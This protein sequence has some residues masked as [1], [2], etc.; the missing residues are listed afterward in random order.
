MSGNGSAGLVGTPGCCDERSFN[1]SS[2][3]GNAGNISIQILDGPTGFF[4][5]DGTNNFIQLIASSSSGNAGN[6]AIDVGGSIHTNWS[7]Y[8]T[9]T[10][11]GNVSINTNPSFFTSGDVYL[12][13][14]ILTNAST[15]RAGSVSIN[16]ISI[17]NVAYIQATGGIFGGDVQLNASN[18]SI[19][20]NG[21]GNPKFISI[22]TSAAIAAGAV[23]VSAT[24][25]ITFA[26]AIDASSPVSG[27]NVSL[28]ITD[29]GNVTF[30]ATGVSSPWR[31]IDTSGSTGGGGDIN[32]F[33]NRSFLNSSGNGDAG[34]VG[35]PG[36]CDERS[37]NASSTSGDAGNIAVTILNGPSGRFGT[38]S[39]ANFMQ[40]IANSATGKGGNI[41]VS[42]KGDIQATW[43]FLANGAEAGNISL[44]SDGYINTEGGAL[45]ADGSNGNA[46][47]VVVSAQSN[48]STGYLSAN[49]TNGLGGNLIAS[50]AN[51]SVNI[52]NHTGLV[53][54][55]AS[56]TFG[57]GQA[58][59]LAKTA[60]SIA[61]TI[62]VSSSAKLGGAAVVN[63]SGTNAP[64]YVGDNGVYNI[65]ARGAISGGSIAV[66]ASGAVTFQDG[67]LGRPLL[68]SAT[69]L[70]GTGGSIFISQSSTSNLNVNL[71]VN[72]GANG[73]QGYAVVTAN[74]TINNS[75]SASP[76]SNIGMFPNTALQGNIFAP[77]NVFLDHDYTLTVGPGNRPTIVDDTTA[78]T[79]LLPAGSL[80]AFSSFAIRNLTIVTASSTLLAPLSVSGSAEFNSITGHGTSPVAVITAG[81]LDVMNGINNAS[82]LGKAPDVILLSNTNISVDG[83]VSTVG[84]DLNTTHSGNIT[85]VGRH[86]DWTGTLDS[87]GAGAS[88]FG[89]QVLVVGHGASS[90]TG[91]DILANGNG[92][93]GA[94]RVTLLAPS[95]SIT[96]HSITASGGNGAG[97]IIQL[98]A[99]QITLTGANSR[100][101]SLDATSF[102]SYAGDI[103]L[104]G[105]TITV[106]NGDIDASGKTSGGR[107]NLHV[108]NGSLQTRDILS[109]GSSFV[110]G[111]ANSGGSVYI[112]GSGIGASIDVEDITVEGL[113]GAFAGGITIFNAY[114]QIT[115]QS[116][117]ARS[118]SNHAG[119]V[120]LVGQ[121]ISITGYVPGGNNTTAGIDL[122]AGNGRGGGL[123]ALVST[124]GFFVAGDVE[125]YGT[126]TGLSAGNLVVVAQSGIV[127][128]GN[129]NVTGYNGARGGTVSMSNA[130]GAILLGNPGSDDLGVQGV[131]TQGT[132]DGG[133][134]IITAGTYLAARPGASLDF[135]TASSDGDGG[136]LTLVSGE[137]DHSLS[138]P[139]SMAMGSINTGGV[140]GGDVLIANLDSGNRFGGV[141]G[142]VE[143]GSINTE[144][145]GQ[146][147]HSGSV[148]ISAT[149]TVLVQG[150]ISTRNTS[151]APGPKAHGGGV[152]IS[153]T[154]TIEIT[155]GLPDVD[156]TIAG[157]IVL[158]GG[159]DIIL[160]GA[161]QPIE[162]HPAANV[163]IFSHVAVPLDTIVSGNTQ[164][165]ITPSF[166]SSNLP[167]GGFIDLQLVGSSLTVN[168]GSDSYLLAPIT[169]TSGGITV[170]SVTG[171][172]GGNSG[173]A[174]ALVSRAAIDVT[175]NVTTASAAN[176]DGG[177]LILYSQIGDVNV[178]GFVSTAG[179]SLNPDTDGGNVSLLAAQAQ[180]FVSGAASN[181][182]INTV[183]GNHA[184]NVQIVGGSGI[185][186]NNEIFAGLTASGGDVILVNPLGS[187][188][189]QN[190]NS[191]TSIEV[192]STDDKGGFVAL[193]L[194]QGRGAGISL[195]GGVSAFSTSSQ[196]TT[197]GTFIARLQQGSINSPSGLTINVSCGGCPSGSRGGDVFISA[198]GAG[199]LNLN[200]N[201]NA[202]GPS[203]GSITV[204]SGGALQLD[205]NNGFGFNAN[206]TDTIDGVA[207]S[208]T[209]ISNTAQAF[210]VVGSGTPTSGSTNYVRGP[211]RVE[212][213]HGGTLT[214]V[215]RGGP[216]SIP[217]FG[218]AID[219]DVLNAAE[220]NGAH[221]TL[222]GTELRV[223]GALGTGNVIDVSGL[224]DGAGG[225]ITIV[226]THPIEPLV[227][228]TTAGTNFINA[229]LRARSGDGLTV[230]AGDGGNIFINAAGGV[231][232]DA[233][234]LDVAGARNGGSITIITNTAST[235]TVDDS[236]T[237]NGV[238]GVLT[239][240]GG[241][242]LDTG[243]GGAITLQNFGGGISIGD[244]HLDVSVQAANGNGGRITL[245]GSN[246]MVFGDLEANGSQ[247]AGGTG[248]G[249]E[250]HVTAFFSP[251]I[252]NGSQS[253]NSFIEGSLNANA[254]ADSG[255]GGLVELTADR[256]LTVDAAQISVLATG[257]GKGGQII[258]SGDSVTIESGDL[259][260]RGSGEGDGGLVRITSNNDVTNSA[261]I[262]TA[263]GSDG[264]PQGG[265]I[266]INL[267]SG[268]F[269]NTDT[270]ILESNGTNNNSAT[271]GSV[272]ITALNNNPLA[273]TNAGTI[274]ATGAAGAGQILFDTTGSS[275]T[276]NDSS[277]LVGTL[278]TTGTISWTSID[279]SISIF[280]DTIGGTVTGQGPDI[281]VI[282][283]SGDLT[284][285]ALDATNGNLILQANDGDLTVGG[286]GATAT[287]GDITLLSG[288]DHQIN[289][290][291]AQ[292]NTVNI[293]T[294]TLN[295]TGAGTVTALSGDILINQ[296]APGNFNMN[297]GVVTANSGNGNVRINTT[298]TITGTVDVNVQSISGL[299]SANGADITITT[300]SDD[301]HTN[302]VTAADGQLTLAA[303]G[304]NLIVD[305]N[306][307]A[308]GG[309]VTLSS[310]NGAS[311]SITVNDVSGESVLINTATLNAVGA[312]PTVEAT[313][314]DI[315]FNQATPGSFA[316]TGGDLVVSSG[317][318]VVFNGGNGI[319]NA[320]VNSISDNGP[321]SPT[322]NATGSDITVTVA[323]GNLTAS[324]VTASS[325]QLT[326]QATAGDLF[327]G[328]NATA[329]G[330]DLTLISGAG[331]DDSITVQNGSGD[332][333]F[334]QTRTLNTTGTTPT[335]TANT[336]DI[337]FNQ[338]TPG[339]FTMAGGNLVVSLG[340][341][342]NF[343][344][345]A[346]VIDAQVTSISDNGA[347]SPTVTATG[348]DIT[349]TT[350][351][352]NLT[353]N[354]VE[355]TSG[356]LTLAAL[357]GN[358][359]VAGDATAT[360]G[361]LNL[362]SANGAANSITIH[363]GSGDSVFIQTRTLIPTGITPT[364]T[365]NDG[366]INFNQAVPGS[367]T[368]NGGNLVVGNG[369]NV[370]F[371]GGN[372]IINATVNSI[373]DNG[374]TSPTVSATGSAITV[375]TATG[376]LT[377]NS[378]SSSSGLLTLAA[379]AGNLL[380][381]GDATATGGNLT[382]RSGSGAAN[383]IT[384]HNG[385]GNSV[386]IQTQTLNP[387]GLSPTIRANTGDINFNQATPGQF[388]M[389][390][391][392]LV[393]GSGRN[394][395]F[396]GG[397]GIIDV[398][399]TS[400]SDNGTSSPTVNATGDSIDISV[401]TGNLTANTVSANNGSLTLEATS[402]NLFVG[403][404]ASAIDGDLTLNSATGATDSVT[405]HNAS[406]DSVFI[407]TRTLNA[408]GS[409]PTI[410]ANVGDIN[411]ND[412]AAGSFS[413][414][415]G[416]LVAVGQNVVFNGGAGT[417]NAAANSINA[418]V[419]GGAETMTVSVASGDLT[420]GGTA[421][422]MTT[423][424]PT[425]IDLT[426]TGGNLRLTG[427]VQADGG[428]L[429]LRSGPSSSLIIA[430][431]GEGSGTEVTANSSTVSNNG[432]LTATDGDLTLLSLNGALLSVSGAG[433]LE[434]TGVG[435]I[436]FN[437]TTPGTAAAIQMTGGTIDANGGANNVNFNGGNGAVT[438]Q[439]IA[440]ILGTVLAN[441]SSVLIQT[442]GGELTAGD[443]DATNGGL[444]LTANGTGLNVIDTANLGATQ[445][446]SL[447]ST[448]ANGITVGSAGGTGVNIDAGTTIFLTANTGGAVAADIVLNEQAH[449]TTTTGNIELTSGRD[450]SVGI[451]A[452]LS[453]GADVLATT[454]GAF[455]MTTGSSAIAVADV[456]VN[457]TTGININGSGAS[458]ATL[459][460]GVPN[461]P[462]ARDSN[463]VLNPNDQGSQYQV[464]N[465]G[466]IQL[467]SSGTAATDDIVLNNA[468]LTSYGANIN[469]VGGHDITSLSGGADLAAVGGNIVLSAGRDLN[470][471][472]G[473]TV[474]AVATYRV[475]S[476]MIPID[477]NQ[478]GDYQGG[479]IF[480]FA[481]TQ[482]PGFDPPDLS[483]QA[484]YLLQLTRLAESEPLTSGLGIFHAPGASVSATAPN[485]GAIQFIAKE[486]GSINVAGSNILHADGGMI[487]IDPPGNITLNGIN[488][489][490][491]APGIFAGGGG[492]S[493]P[494][495]TCCGGGGGDFPLLVLLPVD[496][497]ID[498][499]RTLSLG[500]RVPTDVVKPLEQYMTTSAGE[501]QECSPPANLNTM[502]K[503]APGA[504]VKWA[505]STNLCQPIYFERDDGLVVFGTPGTTFVPE[506][507]KTVL[508]REGTVLAIAG[509]SGLVVKSAS[510]ATA[511]IPPGS[512]V[513]VEQVSSGTVKFNSLQGC[514]VKITLGDG[515]GTK[516]FSAAPGE[517][518]IIGDGALPTPA[519]GTNEQTPPA[520]S[521]TPNVTKAMPTGQTMLQKLGTCNLS[522]FP[523]KLR[524][525]IEKFLREAEEA[526]LGNGN[527]TP[528]S[529]KPTEN[530]PVAFA[531]EAAPRT[532]QI[533]LTPV[534]Y[535]LTAGSAKPPVTGLQTMNTGNATIKAT[536]LG[537]RVVVNKNGTIVLNDGEI[538]VSSHQ[539]T[540]VNIGDHL[541]DIEPNTLVLLSRD[542]DLVKV[543][544]LWAKKLNAVRAQMKDKFVSIVEGQEVAIG[545]S[546]EA[547]LQQMKGD[548]VA[549]R[550]VRG[551]DLPGGHH[552]AC[553]EFAFVSLIQNSELLSKLTKSQD[554]DD[555]V[556]ADRVFKMA[557]CI[558][559]VTRN[560]G[561]Y[562][563][564][565]L[566]Q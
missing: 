478:V 480:L 271:G 543:G 561:A 527:K 21:S 87:S 397:A 422:I 27:G 219:L 558:S 154:D 517:E 354:S 64:I 537:A 29:T 465:S 109:T 390:G 374:P 169:A 385:T 3:S 365:A 311:N 533:D 245:L 415:G 401:S 375:T 472:A 439:S 73:S 102:N 72:G 276:V 36:C 429:N 491:F 15:G 557:A 386:F 409:D 290:S 326:L 77:G 199:T 6:V 20:V 476:T 226:T 153:A 457:A 353:A 112:I 232:V 177:L 34:L 132:S 506:G 30:N 447:N 117:N 4:G 116:L 417:V 155:G 131:S 451:L 545:S 256:E 148:G 100:G 183:G 486:G 383:T 503:Q 351:S 213:G 493:V 99:P 531:Q 564:L 231:Q 496:D 458:P 406:G 300:D 2:V 234:S 338:A 260:A 499:V 332:S 135:T 566:N 316:M 501:K 474:K 129:L 334:I 185:T 402:G 79:Y 333:V 463:A 411:F 428:A 467:N 443:M 23:T 509:K 89:G 149:G 218:N 368:I 344:G 514:E 45:I 339:D 180:V 25:G 556:I 123:I 341:N 404:D 92:G 312:T 350:S 56:G 482:S 97:G 412:A 28:S 229:S 95:S 362:R 264:S 125:A 90:I 242:F 479:T 107:I 186:I 11:G 224:G 391:G 431:A 222:Q 120:D 241:T 201:I 60:I 304:A 285:S 426:A 96:V 319:V 563:V 142:A 394:V 158:Y 555:R 192:G 157:G 293:D 308:I 296:N 485:G 195:A 357:A 384:V 349:I 277:S 315:N 69:N 202:S 436:L 444:T 42:V 421:G 239:A 113:Q 389:T 280:S 329:T 143:I 78:Q 216:V 310:A 128:L 507:E 225:S 403:G 372:G 63:A 367:F 448:G 522:C 247:Q 511:V 105:N 258:L 191:G 291:N 295:A 358:L 162:D 376:N 93:F 137:N 91:N 272:V 562:A 425:G 172:I 387:I 434:T 399:V 396:N 9:G 146:N 223:N 55:G 238:V 346:G 381:A 497:G 278:E 520:P 130:S 322:V 470:M 255:D 171:Q 324:A 252:V 268:V 115:A 512:P 553:S 475:G 214:I 166:V 301:L 119:N 176:G 481:G 542:K 534:D 440:S 198:G 188:T 67:N 565:S 359:L 449:L 141:S 54:L 168:T 335:I 71:N 541:I 209:L 477:N 521:K 163:G 370:V 68:A 275:L 518:I 80:S 408:T 336:G 94:G 39:T 535:L 33:I 211:L 544:T 111:Q 22:D 364:I 206:A 53:S 378:I 473:G 210:E 484:L 265:R 110:Q 519:P 392:A 453:S 347:S 466:E 495:G 237:V 462:D 230:D 150:S 47:N 139:L 12:A 84:F 270:G 152:F 257:D 181:I 136:S 62:N 489:V 134:I 492:G 455:N 371:N 294:T 343:N 323:T 498:G 318:N 513:A 196:A 50:S 207:G 400:I 184:G 262:S 197:G 7:I 468:H 59:V 307:T 373:S 179:D 19:F 14:P 165:T 108:I 423:G 538:L 138:A 539:K 456:L 246:V 410:T 424:G 151:G 369:Q 549:R 174:V 525:K 76:G 170:Q 127:S 420:A 414:T 393:V 49:S 395:V 159:E 85:M 328:G 505:I 88:T 16:A 249:G 35:A 508:L 194:G 240:R 528:L 200:W 554:S 254:G 342:V 26:R 366:D 331:V 515:Q 160:N 340:N 147:A 500:E 190:A 546:S 461:D 398:H 416:N 523:L 5:S 529:Y 44:I 273:I 487:I 282:A 178:H 551:Y 235:L 413:M 70:D 103:S 356:Q 337:N 41:S 58:L 220:G 253:G 494:P 327:V 446:I 405:V 167:A 450:T 360:G 299:V 306:A 98:Q 303:N 441:G 286:A 352:G 205:S 122:S 24:S 263:A 66:V 18:G 228:G 203:G 281:T 121:S 445:S 559:Y 227:F 452:S 81:N 82:Q 288:V 548:K 490:A 437:G 284:T 221:L 407:N 8:A 164:I 267:G 302:E 283:G 182:S 317:Q 243:N 419:V 133:N 1:T 266:E 363:D 251:F 104:F 259:L 418:T 31:F 118:L 248:N 292:G 380:I 43:S 233:S 204:Q 459:I 236:A 460:S 114:G 175:T 156:G 61:R 435:D 208:L 313:D 330:G 13:G 504:V 48:I 516:T 51:G 314:G 388:A 279:A 101:M 530:Q 274:R 189:I 432:T 212:G 106:L 552:I 550:N 124:G 187:I 325:G 297:G 454:G 547:M 464:V 161:T 348:S 38:S 145:T 430:V 532:I 488:F 345:D 321:S 526:S 140:R 298:T 46:G 75:A 244:G 510:G 144:A 427:A 193:I 540:T 289:I 433:T 524:K 74:G 17:S 83:L 361:D 261:L 442:I 57:G 287:N 32:V 382:L 355:A 269:E 379:N 560:R 173:S 438:A 86:V 377:T 483:E 469:V 536:V 65:D 217:N 309:D 52:V 471:P 305:G 502:G 250:I 37:F 215:N 126:G 40:F 320:N 10:N